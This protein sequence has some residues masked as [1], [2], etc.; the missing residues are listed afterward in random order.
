MHNTSVGF[1][2]PHLSVFVPSLDIEHIDSVA[3]EEVSVRIEC[4][5]FTL[6]VAIVVA[7]DR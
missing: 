3:N 7:L 4:Y 2:P 6:L 5:L 1:P